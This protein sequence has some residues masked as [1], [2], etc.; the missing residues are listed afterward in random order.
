MLCPFAVEVSRAVSKGGVC[1]ANATVAL[2]RALA[3][4]VEDA[5]S[6]EQMRRAELGARCC[7]AGRY[8]IAID[9]RANIAIYGVESLAL[10][11]DGPAC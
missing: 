4:R 3:G 6:F 2:A 7:G 5:R 10:C 1:R 8:R 9:R 11:D